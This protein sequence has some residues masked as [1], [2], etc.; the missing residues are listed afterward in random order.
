MV[1]DIETALYFRA[2]TGDTKAIKLFLGSTWAQGRGWGDPPKAGA[3]DK[4]LEEA[5]DPEVLEAELSGQLKAMSSETLR[6]LAGL[7]G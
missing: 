5:Q 7:N 2:Q 4:S 1:D 3:K 6:S